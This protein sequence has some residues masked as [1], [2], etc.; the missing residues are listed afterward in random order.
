MANSNFKVRH[1]LDIGD[2]VRITDAG[3]V[4]GLTDLTIDNINVNG[5]TIASTNGFTSTGS[6]INNGDVLAGT[7][8][9]IGTLT[10]GTIEI[11]QRVLGGTVAGETYI[12][13]NISGS[14]SGS[15]WT[16]NNSQLVA[17]S[18][19]NGVGNIIISSAN[20]SGGFLSGSALQLSTTSNGNI[21]LTPNGTG[22]TTA[23]TRFSA[24]G[25]S[26]LGDTVAI[27]GASVDS[28]GLYPVLG[29]QTHE[30]GRAHV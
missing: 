1:G 2:S 13:A 6:T 17:S 30:I 14:G 8:L 11:G 18:A 26:S 28:A 4:T 10:S 25:G 27:G 15:T 20:S 29:S 12:T 24:L 16:V 23:S 22:I 9:T 21:T 5:N 19:L 7:T 3:V